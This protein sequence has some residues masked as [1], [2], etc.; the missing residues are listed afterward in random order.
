MPRLVGEEAGSAGGMSC[1]LSTDPLGR[2]RSSPWLELL[3]DRGEERMLFVGDDWAEAHHDIEIEDEP[4][5]CW[6][7]AVAGGP[8]RD[9]DAARADR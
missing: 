3:I 9:H 8:G 7:D 2:S 1:R 6:P 4:G 5:G